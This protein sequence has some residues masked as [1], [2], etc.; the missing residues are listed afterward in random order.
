MELD[1]DVITGKVHAQM[2][3][4]ALRDAALSVL[5]EQVKIVRRRGCE[6]TW[7]EIPTSRLGTRLTCSRCPVCSAYIPEALLTELVEAREDR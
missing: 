4:G 3:S 2:V 1:P 7:S 5:T 6:G